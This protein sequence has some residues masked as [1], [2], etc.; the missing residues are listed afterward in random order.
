[1]SDDRPP[2]ACAPLQGD[3]RCEAVVVGAGITGAL[4]SLA[5]T[6]SGMQTVIVD[7]GTVGAG[8]TAASTGLL[9]YELDVPLIDL[10][11]KRGEHDAVHAYRRGLLAIDDLEQEI[12]AS[13]MPCDFSRCDTLYLASQEAD[14]ADLKREY[15]C[16]RHFGFDVRFLDRHALADYCGLQAPAA[17]RSSGDGQVNPYRL[18]QSLLRQGVANGLQAHSDTQVMAARE[19]HDGVTLD[20]AGGRVQARHA[21]FCT[22]YWAQSFLPEGTSRLHSTFAVASQPMPSLRSWPE[23]TLLWETA[24][25][26]FYARQTDDGRIII[27]GEDTRF[28]GDHFDEELLS[29]KAAALLRRFRVLF[30]ELS[31]EASHVWGGA[32]GE[33][34]DGLPFIGLPP[35]RQRTYLALGYGGNGITFSAIAARLIVDLILGRPTADAAVFRFGR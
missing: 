11:H 12:D 33:S 34:A 1:M 22:G 15:D 25:P 23:H 2:V 24:R 18:T 29:Q 30:P 13:E 19:E 10:I 4:V 8:S 31:Y 26:Y 17:L 28:A 7:K 9:Q 35:G 16:R 5:L 3:V 6:Q 20:T 32:F 27:G 14:I 21:V